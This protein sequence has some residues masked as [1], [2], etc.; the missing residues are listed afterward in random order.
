MRKNNYIHFITLISL[1][2]LNCGCATGQDSLTNTQKTE[3]IEMFVSSGDLEA[4]N[5]KRYVH[6]FEDNTSLSLLE[7]IGNCS[8]NVKVYAVR[9]NTSHSIKHI[10]IRSKDKYYCLSLNPDYNLLEPLLK[11]HAF[12]KQ[13]ECNID[14]KDVLKMISSIYIENTASRSSTTILPFNKNKQ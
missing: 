1:L 5:K 7:E 10:Y 11:A 3:I 14:R 9:L 8:D 4:K 13:I 12:Y 6:K 2:I